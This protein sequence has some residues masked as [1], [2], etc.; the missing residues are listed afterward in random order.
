MI[1]ENEGHGTGSAIKTLSV[2][3][4][5][6]AELHPISH[7]YLAL[8]GRIAQPTALEVQSSLSLYPVSTYSMNCPES[9]IRITF[10][11]GWQK[12]K[13]QAH[14][15]K[16]KEPSYPKGQLSPTHFCW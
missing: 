15:E 11:R 6:A 13:V 4:L 12:G 5:A 8:K 9:Q 7:I 14:N 16:R 10:E 3:V 2:V 1:T